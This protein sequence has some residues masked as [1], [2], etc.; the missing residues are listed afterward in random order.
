MLGRKFL[1]ASKKISFFKPKGIV[2]DD[3]IRKYPAVQKFIQ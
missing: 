3:L 1:I 2:W